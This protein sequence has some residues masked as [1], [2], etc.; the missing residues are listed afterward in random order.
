[1]DILALRAQFSQGCVEAEEVVLVQPAGA[2]ATQD[3]L[4][5]FL[6]VLRPD[7]LFVIRRTDVDQRLDGR[8]AISGM[9]WRIMDGVAVDLSDV[10]I[11]LD[12]C[13]MVGVDSVSYS[14]YFVGSRVMVV[15]ELFPVGPFNESDNSPR[16]FW[17]S[18]MVFAGVTFGL[19]LQMSLVTAL[20]LQRLFW[21][22]SYLAC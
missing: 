18:S 10:E 6:R 7:K 5:K 16:S 17:C 11:L 14:P 9:K 4:G 8:G 20:L 15:C 12:F 13:H 1:M 21:L 2:T 22:S 19:A 3:V